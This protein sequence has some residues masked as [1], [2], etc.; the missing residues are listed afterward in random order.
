MT[1]VNRCHILFII[2]YF[3]IRFFFVNISEYIIEYIDKKSNLFWFFFLIESRKIYSLVSLMNKEHPKKQHVMSTYTCFKIKDWIIY[4][5][6]T[7]S[8]QD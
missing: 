2:E 8:S 7:H 1:D 6:K 3:Y 4:Y 5:K